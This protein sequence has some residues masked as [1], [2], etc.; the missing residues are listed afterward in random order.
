MRVV[1]THPTA[2]RDY[3]ILDKV[4]AGIVLRGSEVKA[5][6]LGRVSIKEAFAKIKNGEVW[7]IKAYFGEYPPAGN[8][9]HDPLRRRKL[10]LRRRQIVRLTQS[11]QQKGMTLVPLRMYFNRR[12]LLK[13]ELALAKGR[14]MHDKREVIRKKEARRQIRRY[15]R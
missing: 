12:G 3:Q 4:E 8:R 7:L 13:V 1:A 10:L 11:V 5:A 15:V 14:P 2:K 6:R 9:Q